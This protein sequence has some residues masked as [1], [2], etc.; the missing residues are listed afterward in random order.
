MFG[1]NRKGG[2]KGGSGGK[3]YGGG[4]KFGGKKFGGG[5]GKRSFGGR[6]SDR[7]AMHTAV[8]DQCRKEC[9]VPFKP[10]G[11][12]P[13]FCN[14]CF[15]K[16]GEKGGDYGRKDYGERS[17]E[18]NDRPAANTGSA[19]ADQYRKQFEIVNAKL[20]KI[21]RLLT[22]DEPGDDEPGTFV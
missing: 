7:P 17:F 16:L 13:V 6:D 10:T 20:D 2:F 14:N 9:E 8:C 18:R 21:I 4:G 11:D 1:S 19:N 5:Y 15:K 22:D 3:R 12:R